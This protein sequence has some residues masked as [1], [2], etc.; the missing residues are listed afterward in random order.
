MPKFYRSAG[1]P[2]RAARFLRLR[3]RRHPSIVGVGSPLLTG[4]YLS[5]N[6]EIQT[7]SFPENSRRALANPQSQRSL[8]I[9]TAKFTS[10]RG[11]AVSEAGEEWEDL[12]GRARQI[13]EHAI[14]NLDRYLDEFCGNVER[15]GGRVL[16]ARD[17]A[18]ANSL[19]KELAVSNGVKLAVKSKSMMTEEIE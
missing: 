7:D 9:S 19:I 17:A 18:E 2:A 3:Q 8:T 11:A 5:M 16:W 6:H 14:A 1:E 12:R 10:A 13:K 15:L 4:S